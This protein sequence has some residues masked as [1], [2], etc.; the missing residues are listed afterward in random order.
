[1]DHRKPHHSPLEEHLPEVSASELA[2]AKQ[3]LHHTN[4]QVPVVVQP[5]IPPSSWSGPWWYLLGG[6]I[7]GGGIWWYY[8]R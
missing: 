6:V 2:Q 1:M 4:L 7:I 8:R 5:E 3:S